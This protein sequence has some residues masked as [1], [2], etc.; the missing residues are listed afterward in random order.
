MSRQALA[1]AAVL[2]TAVL[3]GTTGTAATFS[4]A[5]PLAIGA[6]ALGVG[7]LGQG[8]I[9][10]PQIIRPD[11][12]ALLVRSWPL[13]LSGACGVVVYPL[14]FY[15]SMHVAG[16]AIGTMV[17]LAS[18]PILAGII[19]RFWLKKPLNANW[20]CA[21]VLGTVGTVLLSFSHQGST[22]SAQSL[23]V[24][25]AL[26]L[27]AGLTYAWY[28]L[29][30]GVLMRRSVPRSVAMESVFGLGGIGLLPVILATWSEHLGGQNMLVA[31][32][33]ALVPMFLGYVLF[34]FGLAHLTAATATTITLAEPAVA[35]VLAVVIVGEQL[36]PM[37]WL[38]LAVI[39]AALVAVALPSRGLPRN[40]AESGERA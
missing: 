27:L 29:A 9:A 3:W 18:A 2:V 24:G 8:L 4:T 33:M 23:G 6:I 34:G 37:G 26:G 30:S 22:V 16:V 21:A 10:L 19:E 11:N 31:V 13:V 32:Y 40:P 7:G 36:S 25:I 1:F 35:T 20:V 28:S 39:A 5:G 14:A 17:S 12:R 15:S 38:G